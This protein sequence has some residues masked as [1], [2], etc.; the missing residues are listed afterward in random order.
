MSATNNRPHPCHHRQSFPSHPGN[1]HQE[2][3]SLGQPVSV[4]W[5]D[6]KVAR[7]YRRIDLAKWVCWVAANST[8][9]DNVVTAAA[10][11]VAA[12]TGISCW[13]EGTQGHYL[14][15]LPHCHLSTKTIGYFIGHLSPH[16][17]LRCY[18]CA[19][20]APDVF[21][22]TSWTNAKSVSS[23]FFLMVL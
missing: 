21:R 23:F 22:D 12:W 19:F 7:L 11:F 14:C 8:L 1:F 6:N 10:A 15:P 16:H 13:S 2:G 4:F 5:I 17:F 18:W 20:Q 3:N 9:K